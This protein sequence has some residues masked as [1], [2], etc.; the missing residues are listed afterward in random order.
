MGNRMS[1]RTL[2]YVG[3]NYRYLSKTGCY[4]GQCRNTRTV[5]SVI[6]G[7][8]YSHRLFTIFNIIIVPAGWYN[9]VNSF[10]TMKTIYLIHNPGAGDEAHSKETLVHLIEAAGYVC[11][12][13][14][15]DNEHWKNI[16]AETD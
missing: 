1:H 14:S 15:T 16:P 5:N 7:Y 3:C 8:Q 9:F 10:L 12:Y 6:I 4:T 13:C 2:L 11:R